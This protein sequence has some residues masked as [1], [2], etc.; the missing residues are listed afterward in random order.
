MEK[1]NN[2]FEEIWSELVSA[3]NPVCFIDSRPD[4]DAFCSA[5]SM[6][7][8]L[9][10]ENVDLKLFWHDEIPERFSTQVDITTIQTSVNPNDF[11]FSPYD[12]LLILD[13]GT[14]PHVTRKNDFQKPENIKIVNIDHHPSNDLYGDLNY[15]DAEAIATCTLMYRMFKTLALPID[16]SLGKLIALGIL[17]DSGKFGYESTKPEDLRI[18]A[19]MMDLGVNLFQLIRDSFGSINFETMKLEAATFN[20]LVLHDSG[21]FA[22]TTVTREDIAKRGIDMSNITMKPADMI[23]YL[24]GV[25]F[26]FAM[27]EDP[28]ENGT[29]HVSLRSH[30]PGYDVSVF[31]EALDGGGHKPAAGG[32]VKGASTMAAAVETVIKV[33]EKH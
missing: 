26:V 23:K 32:V 12:L 8:V 15:V 28:E 2:T 4:F 18:V 5:L 17:T 20:N 29:Y 30:A 27:K 21:K 10:A 6:Q 14:L 33:I 3:Q 22:Y 9:A 16:K 11:D 31:A 13:S 19:D 25:D 7:K 1:T 24:D